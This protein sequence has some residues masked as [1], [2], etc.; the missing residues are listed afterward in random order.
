MKIYTLKSKKSLD[1]QLFSRFINH[2][3]VY[4]FILNRFLRISTLNKINKHSDYSTCL[5]RG[6]GNQIDILYEPE[7]KNFQI[8]FIVC[9]QKIPEQTQKILEK[10]LETELQLQKGKDTPRRYL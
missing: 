1:D 2:P 5:I 3:K 7:P 10:I 6:A 9:A 4:S 8:K